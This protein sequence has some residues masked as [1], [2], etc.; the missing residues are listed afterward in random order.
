ML[1]RLFNIKLI[2]T[3]NKEKYKFA[4]VYE[5]LIM[6]GYSDYLGSVR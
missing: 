6:A 5:A 2:F 4:V 1:L 3:K